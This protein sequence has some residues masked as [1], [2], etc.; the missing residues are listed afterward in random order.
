MNLTVFLFTTLFVLLAV[1]V[2]VLTSA[3]RHYAE[4]NRTDSI[5]KQDLG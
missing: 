3:Y 5:H 1:W 4:S 2:W